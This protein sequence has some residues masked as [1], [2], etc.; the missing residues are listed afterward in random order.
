MYCQLMLRIVEIDGVEFSA[1]V[2]P[3]KQNMIFIF[4]PQ[5]SID[6]GVIVLESIESFD[7]GK[8]VHIMDPYGYKISLWEPVDS[9]LTKLG[10]KTTK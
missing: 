6:I 7:Y 10:G 5:S 4:V 2:N 1:P 8:F 9:V 3:N